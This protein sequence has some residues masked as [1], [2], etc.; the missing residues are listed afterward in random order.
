VVP[1]PVASSEDDR[2]L[3]GAASSEKKKARENWP[4][5]F[6]IK[7]KVESAISAAGVFP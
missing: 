6:R 4:F 5:S 7:Q 3:P 2:P 1:R